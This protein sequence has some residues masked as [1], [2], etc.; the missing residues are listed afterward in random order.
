[1]VDGSESRV[2]EKFLLRALLPTLPID[3]NDDHVIGSAGGAI[4]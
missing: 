3:G 4:G 2:G 1:M